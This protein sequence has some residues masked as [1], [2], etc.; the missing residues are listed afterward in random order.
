MVL[1]DEITIA[2]THLKELP[3]TG[4][5]RHRMNH[6]FRGDRRL[7]APSTASP[8]A[9][10]F[11]KG[12]QEQAIKTTKIARSST[13]NLFRLERPMK[14]R[15]RIP[16]KLRN[17]I[18]K[19]RRRIAYVPAVSDTISSMKELGIDLKEDKKNNE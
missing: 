12:H 15:Q 5:R 11:H 13:H 4:D 17:L 8:I 2:H 1:S 14:I 18:D 7:D 6:L 16:P 10:K 3:Q 9:M 19:I